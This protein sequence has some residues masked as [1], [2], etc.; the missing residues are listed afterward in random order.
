MTT[1]PAWQLEYRYKTVRMLS[2]ICFPMALAGLTY[3]HLCPVQSPE[4]FYTSHVQRIEKLE[5]Q[6]G[7]LGRD[8]GIT[9]EMRIMELHSLPPLI[10]EYAA[11]LSDPRIKQ[12]RITYQKKKEEYKDQAAILFPTYFMLFI[13]IVTGISAVSDYCKYRKYPQ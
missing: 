3:D 12:E 5:E 10:T 1:T 9:N 11:L 2:S 8:C 4:K 13:G 7:Y 6:M